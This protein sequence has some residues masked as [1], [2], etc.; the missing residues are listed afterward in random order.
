MRRFIVT[1]SWLA[2]LGPW[3]FACSTATPAP[4][5]TVAPQPIQTSPQ[6]GDKAP[7]FT[8]ADSA[9]NHVNL[10]T[11]AAEFKSTVLVFYLSHT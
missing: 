8:L 6:A 10:A 5:A 11:V 4:T 2:S 9:G 1:L 3:L 7:D